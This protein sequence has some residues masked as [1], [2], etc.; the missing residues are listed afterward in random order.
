MFI[1][2]HTET[3]TGAQILFSVACLRASLQKQRCLTVSSWL[4]CSVSLRERVSALFWG[5]R[6]HEASVRALC[7]GPV[8]SPDLSAEA[9]WCFT[10]CRW[11]CCSEGKQVD[12]VYFTAAEAKRRTEEE[13]FKEQKPDNETQSDS[14]SG[15][16]WLTGC[17]QIQ[18]PRLQLW[19]ALQWKVS[20]GSSS[21]AER[22]VSEADSRLFIMFLGC[23]PQDFGGL[24]VHLSNRW[25]H[26]S[27]ISSAAAT[28]QVFCP[29]LD[30]E[31]FRHLQHPSW[32]PDSS[33]S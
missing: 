26:S 10:A 27:S 14:P 33:S 21:A 7:S 29:S 24:R 3:L 18:R 13:M 19:S 22:D 2:T 16:V 28:R 11:T 1:H 17:A 15:T 8:G 23:F 30:M 31:M 6:Y 12:V 20:R 9:C 32:G 25:N 5:E 4:C